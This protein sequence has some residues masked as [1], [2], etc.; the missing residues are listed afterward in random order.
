M[1]L[2]NEAAS[3]KSTASCAVH[4]FLF[5]VPSDW[6]ARHIAYSN[7]ATNQNSSRLRESCSVNGDFQD[8]SSLWHA[9]AFCQTTKTPPHYFPHLSSFHYPF[10]IPTVFYL[11]ASKALPAD[12]YLIAFLSLLFPGGSFSSHTTLMFELTG[13]SLPAVF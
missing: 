9:V 6:Q 13:K 3:Q 2:G 10:F 11:L 5:T 7:V 12:T 1:N 4:R 8:Y